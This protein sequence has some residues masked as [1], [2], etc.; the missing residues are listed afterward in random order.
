MSGQG[1]SGTNGYCHIVDEEIN[2]NHLHS[3]VNV[4]TECEKPMSKAVSSYHPDDLY[5]GSTQL[6]HC[7]RSL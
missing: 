1:V 5:A 6:P 7:S 4:S 3:I 2:R